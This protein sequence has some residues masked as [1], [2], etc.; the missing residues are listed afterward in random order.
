M[1]LPDGNIYKPQERKRRFKK[2]EVG[3]LSY[4]RGQAR[5]G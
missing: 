5:A 1:G 4:N 3:I 2:H